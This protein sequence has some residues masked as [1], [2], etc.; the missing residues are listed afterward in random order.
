MAGMA[1]IVIKYV[2]VLNQF[3]A[4]GGLG[5]SGDGVHGVTRTE[6]AGECAGDGW[7][8]KDLL[9]LR[10]SGQDVMQLPSFSKTFSSA[11]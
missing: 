11:S 7:V 1:R 8:V 5:D 2:T 3:Y 10:N 9:Y 4:P 6:Q